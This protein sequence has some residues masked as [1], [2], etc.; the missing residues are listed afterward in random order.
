MATLPFCCA[1]GRHRSPIVTETAKS[2]TPMRLYMDVIRKCLL[3]PLAT[4]CARHA[5]RFA[6]SM[7]LLLV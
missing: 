3:A 7:T 6:L 1:F 2:A 4:V 5:I